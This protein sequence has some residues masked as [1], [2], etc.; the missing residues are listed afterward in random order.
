MQETEK[1]MYFGAKPGTFEKANRLR[2]Q[3]TSAELLLWER[4]KNK[5]LCNVR[6]RRQHPIDLF[7]ADF[8]CFAARLVV[9]VDGTVH[10]T[11]AEY[12]IGRTAEMEQYDI[13]VIRF[14]NEEVENDT[15]MVIGRIKEKIEMRLKNKRLE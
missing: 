1:N 12:D 9:E 8:F 11:Q 14:T 2:K 7:I 5:Q 13:E 4:L 3:M 15:D 10:E 6:F